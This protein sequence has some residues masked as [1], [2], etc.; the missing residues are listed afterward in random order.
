M[1]RNLKTYLFATV[2]ASLFFG[3]A[4]SGAAV[5]STAA[6]LNVDEAFASSFVQKATMHAPAGKST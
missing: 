3:L 1:R 4:P 2:C 5:L 6:D